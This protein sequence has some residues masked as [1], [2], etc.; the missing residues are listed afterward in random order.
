MPIRIWVGS[1]SVLPSSSK[2]AVKR[3]ITNTMEKIMVAA[4]TSR[5]I[6]G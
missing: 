6:A 1:G 2:I 3:G 4:P 5:M